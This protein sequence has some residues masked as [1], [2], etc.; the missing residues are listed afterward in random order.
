MIL[1]SMK[2]LTCVN[3]IWLELFESL[4]TAVKWKEVDFE[5]ASSQVKVS[6]DF[7]HITQTVS[8]RSSLNNNSVLNVLILHLSSPAS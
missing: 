8:A 7:V 1:P 6:M 5:L 3:F 2:V 4:N